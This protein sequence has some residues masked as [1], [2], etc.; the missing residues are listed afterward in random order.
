[1]AKENPVCKRCRREGKKLFLKGERCLT[2]KCSF[3]KRSYAPG[4]SSTSRPSKLSD[5]GVQLREKQKAKTRYGVREKQFENYYLKAAKTK[6]A[7]GEKLLQF[8]ELRLDNIVYKIG[9]GAS[10]RQARQLVKHGKIKVNDKKVDI[11]SYQ[12]S[13]KDIIKPVDKSIIK[14]TK[15]EI[16][17][18]LK[19]NKGDLTAE[20]VKIP[21]RTEIDS[22][23]SEGL[24]VEF[25]SR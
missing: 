13:E 9:L 3:T 19:F 6:E 24:I 15:T 22:D 10:M 16:P 2:P 17:V 5:Y 20:I 12:V 14:L 4:S 21:S 1:M 23:I 11:P 8:L 25:Y 7:R 18:W